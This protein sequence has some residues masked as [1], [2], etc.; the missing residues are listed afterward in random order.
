VKAIMQK[1]SGPSSELA[2]PSKVRLILTAEELFAERGIEGVS[3]RE[4]SLAAGQGNN[5]AVQYHFKTRQGLV[6]AIFDYR[7]AQMDRI[8]SEALARLFDAGEERDLRSLLMVLL[9]PHLELADE[10][11]THPHARFLSQYVTRY[12][13]AGMPHISTEAATAAALMKI[14]NLIYDRVSLP[15]ELARKRLELVMLLF[16]SML[17]RYDVGTQAG[18]PQPSLQEQVED[19]LDMA[20]AALTVPRPAS[21]SRFSVGGWLSQMSSPPADGE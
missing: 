1:D 14:T 4:I 16:L 9:L 8:R 2:T 17:I 18:H 13:P 12:R 3:L 6:A 19:T 11:G 5:A 10:R 15:R 7:V 20:L 21:R